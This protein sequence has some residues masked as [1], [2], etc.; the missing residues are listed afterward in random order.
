LPDP[1]RDDSDKT[2][3]GAMAQRANV[4]AV[5]DDAHVAIPARRCGDFT[6]R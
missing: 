6:D 4:S 2:F 3:A 1:R 5:V